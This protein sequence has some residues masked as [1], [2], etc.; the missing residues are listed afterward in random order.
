MSVVAAS[1]RTYR[2]LLRHRNERPDQVGTASIPD[3]ALLRALI[4]AG[5]FLDPSGVLAVQLFRR[6]AE[7]DQRHCRR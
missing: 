5:A 4:H 2:Q 3:A 1:S 6:M 7:D